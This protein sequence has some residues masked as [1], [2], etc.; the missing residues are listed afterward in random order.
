[1]DLITNNSPVLIPLLFI[2]AAMLLPIIAWKRY[3]L[4]WPFTVLVSLTSVVIAAFNVTRVME[5]GVIHYHLGDWAPPVGIEYVL[6][7]LSAFVILVINAVALLVLV[8]SKIMVKVD[9]PGKEMPYYTA[10]LLMLCGFNGIVITGDLFNLYVFLEISSLS[11]YGL[12]ASGR[13]KQAPVASF[14]YL[15][16]GTVAGS[17]Y[18]LG[19][20]FLY[21]TT[22]SLNMAD[23]KAIIP[24]LLNSPA[25]P[26]ILIALAM[27]V[28]GMAIKMALFPMH[29]WLPDAYT[30]APATTSALVAPTG[31]KV[32]SYVLLRIMLFVFG[33]GYVTKVLPVAQVISWLAAIG[34]IY[35]SIMAIAQKEMKRMLA[36]SSVAQIGYIAMGIGLANKL[37]LIGAVLHILNHAFMKG[38]LFLVSA[39]F[40]YKLGHSNISK[41]DNSIR[42]K[43]PWTMVAFTI[44]ALSMVGIPPMAGFFSKWYLALGTIQNKNWIFLVVILVSS[45]LNAVYFFRI[46]EK[47]YMK[48][49]TEENDHNDANHHDDHNAAID[50]TENVERDEVRAS[51][52]VPT[53]VMAVSLIVLG[54]LNAFIVK[55][56]I[57]YIAPAVGL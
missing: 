23:V 56:V 49:K 45:L 36:Y 47:T 30:Y 44:A 27:M 16:M 31:T 41:M 35:G 6:D 21:I 12:L 39:N 28:L 7:H 37:A 43:M 18:L 53:L 33:V 38:A 51:M 1:M 57:A 32:G 5:H 2:A 3:N 40:R 11:L 46:L 19:V 8:H 25:A 24:T 10:A 9:M 55:G 34:I 26:T 29:G 17:F 20:G 15:I 54:V 4:A 13:E 52:L 22:G 14:R 50:E 48:P 42:K